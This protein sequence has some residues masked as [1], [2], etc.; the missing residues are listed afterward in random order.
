MLVRELPTARLKQKR[1]LSTSVLHPTPLSATMSG[2]GI[3]ESKC[4]HCGATLKRHIGAISE[5]L[6]HPNN[7]E[8]CP[9]LDIRNEE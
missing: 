7:L 3:M 1:T 9:K 5:W 8:A 6:V 4:K 2:G